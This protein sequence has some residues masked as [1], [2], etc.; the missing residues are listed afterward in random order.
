MSASTRSVFASRPSEVAKARARRG[1]MRIAGTPAAA[2][3]TRKGVSYPPEASKATRAPLRATRC[4]KALR[5][6]LPIRA[7][8]SGPTTSIQLFATSTPKTFSIMIP[9]FQSHGIG[10]NRPNQVCRTNQ[11]GRGSGPGTMSLIAQSIRIL[12][13]S[14]PQPASHNPIGLDISGERK[15]EGRSGP[16]PPPVP[17]RISPCRGRRFPCGPRRSCRGAPAG[18]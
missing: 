15:H 1:L 2:N 13:S 6:Q 12:T 4:A 7:C 17:A 9:L 18:G 10:C 3:A 14:R 11:S 16:P 5:S 8:P